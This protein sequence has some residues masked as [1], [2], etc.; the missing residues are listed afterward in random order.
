MRTTLPSIRVNE[1]IIDNMNMAVSKFNKDSLVKLSVQEFRRL[2]Y[3]FLSQS[4]LQNKQQ[5]IK[6]MLQLQ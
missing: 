6:K 2:S 3:E 4:I 5:E 1:K